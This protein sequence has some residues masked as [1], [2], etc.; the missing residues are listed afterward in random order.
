M[1]LA[2]RWCGWLLYRLIRRRCLLCET[3]TR[4]CVVAG[5]M[6]WICLR[7]VADLARE[8]ADQAQ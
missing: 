7:C 2:R 1:S 5:D 3:W 4:R 6:G 8:E